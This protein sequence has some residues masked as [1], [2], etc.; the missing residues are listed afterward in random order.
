MGR[1]EYYFDKVKHK[2]ASRRLTKQCAD[3][4]YIFIKESAKV[5]NFFFKNVKKMKWYVVIG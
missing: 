5:Y 1:R 2:P 4:I 3:N